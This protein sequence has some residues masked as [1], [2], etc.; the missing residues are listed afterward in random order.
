MRLGTLETTCYCNFVS[1]FTISTGCA[2]VPFE[3]LRTQDV[4]LDYPPSTVGNVEGPFLGRG[5][6]TVVG[7]HPTCVRCTRH[8]QCGL[9]DSRTFRYYG[10]ARFTV[11]A[12]L[13]LLGRQP[14]ITSTCVARF[15]GYFV[16]VTSL[17]VV[18]KNTFVVTST[19][20]DRDEL[21]SCPVGEYRHRHD[22][23]L[24]RGLSAN[25]RVLRSSPIGYTVCSSIITE[26]SSHRMAV[27]S[28][29]RMI[30]DPSSGPT[31]RTRLPK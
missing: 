11:I 29:Q 17:Q 23:T 30:F 27:P 22:A 5:H 1:G 16:S 25:H 15:L 8:R 3:T 24:Y 13:T 7:V 26:P 21:L 14:L 4:T 20:N 2:F 10:H 31:Q 6:A 18:E 12:L 9:G 28:S 19:V